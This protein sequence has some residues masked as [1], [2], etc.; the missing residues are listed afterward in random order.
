MI[1]TFKSRALGDLWSTGK[2][3]RIDARMHGRIM[4]CLTLLNRARAAEDTNVAGYRFHAL[5]GFNP[6]RFTLHVNGPWCITFEFR[7][8]NAYTI[9]FEQY[10]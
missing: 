6:T 7:D 3:G 10:H 9:D 8:G 1:E 2:T 4:R 5:R